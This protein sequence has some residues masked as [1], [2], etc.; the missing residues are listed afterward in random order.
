MVQRWDPVFHIA[1]VT[2]NANNVI[3]EALVHMSDIH[4]KYA[5]LPTSLSGT[6]S[7]SV[8]AIYHHHYVFSLSLFLFPPHITYIHIID[9]RTTP[10]LFKPLGYHSLRNPSLPLP[11]CRNRHHVVQHAAYILNL[12]CKCLSC[13]V[14]RWEYT[15]PMKTSASIYLPF[16]RLAAV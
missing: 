3:P 12:V 14:F 4:S 1:R 8:A 7:F 16:D 9:R 15:E 10:H 2:R 5:Q 13:G 11:V 6:I